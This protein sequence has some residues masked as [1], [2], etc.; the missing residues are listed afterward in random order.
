[1]SRYCSLLCHD[2]QVLVPGID[3]GQSIRAEH[4]G[5]SRGAEPSIYSFCALVQALMFVTPPLQGLR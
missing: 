3:A 4:F 2:D 5:S 1:M